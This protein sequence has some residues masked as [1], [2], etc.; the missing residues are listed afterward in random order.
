[1]AARDP[2]AVALTA[3]DDADGDGLAAALGSRYAVVAA[4]AARLIGERELSELAPQLVAAFEDAIP[5]GPKSDPK[6]V[7]KRAAIEALAALAVDEAPTFRRAAELVQLEAVWGAQEDFAGGLRGAAGIA[8]ARIGAV[9]AHL[10]LT[11][12]LMDPQRECRSLA[13]EG[14]VI[15]GG[16]RSELVIRARLLAGLEDDPEDDG[17]QFRALLELDVERSWPFV[18]R[19]L[20]H[21]QRAL[22]DEA[23]LALGEHRITAALPQL[24]AACEAELRVDDRRAL[25]LAIA[26]LRCD[27]ATTWLAASLRDGST[28][29]ARLVIDAARVLIGNRA[30]V[31]A[32]RAAAAERGEAT[33]SAA[34]EQQFTGL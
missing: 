9:D 29:E 10:V 26:L 20:A 3:L 23:A 24:I 21:G 16:E 30:A 4:K 11:S 17:L 19:W 12:L 25:V 22:A 14:L 32:L 33:I 31:E 15:A 13:V 8:L 7:L 18:A 28:G 6:C 5:N 34:L 2:V 1:M 27:G